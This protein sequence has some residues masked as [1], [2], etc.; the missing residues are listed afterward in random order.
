M[1]KWNK[2]LLILGSSLAFVACSD[3]SSDA[4]RESD[5]SSSGEVL[6]SS[7]S[8]ESSDS[9]FDTENLLPN[10]DLGSKFGTNLWLSAGKNGLYSLWFVD[11]SN[12]G[13]SYGTV[14]SH[15]DLS[16]GVL[17]FD[18]TSGYVFAANH[19]KGDSVL[20]WIKSGIRLEFSMED[21][22]LMVKIDDAEPV[23]VKKATR[24]VESGYLAKSDSLVG[25]VLEW[26]DGDSSSIYRFYR[27]GEYVREV[28]GKSASFE[29]GY[30]DVHRQHLLV[31]PVYFSGSVS[32]LGSYTVKEN[33]GSYELDNDIS[34]KEYSVS[35]M[36]VDYP[37]RSLI[38]KSNWSSESND[39]LRWTLSFDGE[40][41]TI[42]GKTG[43]SEN[44]TK[45]QREGAWA[46]F[47]DYLVLSVEKCSA[48]KK[49]ECPAVEYG[50]LSK[51][52]ASSFEF[53][54]SDTSDEYAAPKVWTAI[55][56]E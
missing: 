28:A 6:S 54:N 56:E 18:T 38:S 14:V 39:T 15:A 1:K 2:L 17:A 35:S 31:V 26:S 44:T 52:E 29:A 37:D 27:N 12:A 43:L 53:E 48:V 30:Y 47:G 19:A 16:S 5:S 22:T 36:T 34:K 45:I 41:Y 20:A 23:A 40:S 32:I 51:V 10:M 42:K 25:K 11:S 49:M 46:V 4:N 13:A 50:T 24:Q 21:S 55:E 3:S 33:G 7:S 9:G 8:G